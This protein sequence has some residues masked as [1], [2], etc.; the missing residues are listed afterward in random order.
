M[1]SMSRAS[2]Q[3]IYA[4]EPEASTLLDVRLLAPALLA[5]GD[6]FEEANRILNGN[7]AEVRIAVRAGFARGSFEIDLQVLQS[8]FDQAKSLLVGGGVT[9]ALN[10][11]GL[12]GLGHGA[13]MG[14]IKLVRWLKGRRAKKVSTLEDGNV[15][16]EADGERLSIPELVWLLFESSRIRV[17]MGMI[18]APLEAP[19]MDRVEF[20]ADHQDG[21]EIIR[22]EEREAFTRPALLD[23]QAGEEVAVSTREVVLEVVRPAF[24]DTFKWTFS[25]GQ[26]NLTATIADERFV[27]RVESREERFAKGD[28]LRLQ[29]ESRTTRDERGLHTVHTVLCVHGR[30]PEYQQPSLYAEAEGN[31]AD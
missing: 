7:R 13:C 2:I 10:L 24:R 6:M 16:I 18:V 12:L 9:S 27:A 5:V 19:G 1:E 25:D 29:L 31:A 26:T 3:V 17:S 11:A 22:S 15:E 30:L 20:R 14:V 8:I 28:V 4:G 21:G 23:V